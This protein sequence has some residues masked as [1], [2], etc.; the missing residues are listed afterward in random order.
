MSKDR[1][2][3]L[4]A[5]YNEKKITLEQFKDEL[6]HQES[7]KILEEER[8]YP[9]KGGFVIGLLD[10]ISR[11][12]TKEEELKKILSAEVA[13]LAP[14]GITLPEDKPCQRC[15]AI[16]PYTMWINGDGP[17]GGYYCEACNIYM[18]EEEIDSLRARLV[19]RLLLTL[20]RKD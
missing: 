1:I 17:K 4:L 6:L 13:D 5:A 18:D 19:K 3:E 11:F 16:I 2:N 7:R 15:G 14:V 9:I 8:I 10:L 20:N 12:I